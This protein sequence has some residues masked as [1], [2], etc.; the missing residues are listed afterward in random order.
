MYQNMLKMDLYIPCLGLRFTGNAGT[1]TS[2]SSILHIANGS[3]QILQ[4]AVDRQLPV[5]IGCRQTITYY[6]W[7]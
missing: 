1:D 4:M 7:V 2:D 5:I 3:G 6:K